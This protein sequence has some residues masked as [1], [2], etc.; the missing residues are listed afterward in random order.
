MGEPAACATCGRRNRVGA[1][2]CAGCGEALPAGCP[3]CGRALAPDANFCDRCGH[4]IPHAAPSDDAVG[5]GAR[6]PGGASVAAAEPAARPAARAA[7]ASSAVRKTVTVLF[8]DLVGSTAFGERV[9][10]ELAREAMARY[11]ELARSAV[12]TN[13]GTVAKFIGDGVMALFGVPRTGEDDA[14]RAVAAGVDLQRDFEAMRRQ[15]ADRFGAEVGLRVGINTGEVVIAD[16]DADVV[17]DALNTAARLEAECPPGAVVVGAETWRLTRSSVGYAPLGEIRVRGRE[18]PVAAFRVVA[19]TIEPPTP[20]REAPTPFVGRTAELDDLRRMF[21]AVVAESRTRVA[22]IV[23][24]PGVGKTRLARELARRIRLE[25]QIMYLECEQSGASTYAP[26]ADLLRSITRIHDGQG[27]DEILAALRALVGDAVDAPRVTELLGAMVGVGPA[28]STE[29]SFY[30]ARRL[31]E[32]HAAQRPLVLIV[33]DLQWA[34]PVLFDLLDHLVRWVSAPMMVVALA[35]PELREV[36]PGLTEPGHHVGLAMALEGLDPDATT[37]LASRLLGSKPLPPELT[38]RLPLSTDGNPLFV[39]ELVRMLADDGVL[40]E[41][42]DGWALAVDV[43]GIDVPPTIQSLLATRI[44]RMP[45]GDRRIAELASVVGVEFPLGALAAIADDFTP[46]ELEASL[47]RLRRREQIQPTGTTWGDQPLYRFHHVLVRDAAYRRLLKKVRADLHP[48]VAAWLEATGDGVFAEDDVTIAHHYEQA[49]RYAR[50]LAVGATGDAGVRAARLFRR[51]ARAA[52]ASDDLVTAGELARRAIDCLDDRDGDAGDE[53]A[54]LLILGCEALLSAGDVH[55]GEALVE[56]LAAVAGD[57]ERLAAWTRCFRAQLV[58]LTDPAGLTDA[59]SSAADAAGQL[60]RLGDHAGVA[61]ARL[62]RAAAVVR[63]GEVAECEVELDRALTAARTAGDQRRITSVLAAAPVAALWGPSPVRRA[64]GRCL[65][66]MRLSR[67]TSDSPSVEAIAVRCQAVLEAMRGN[68]DTARVLLDSARTIAEEVG[69]RHGLLETDLYA[70]IVELLAGRPRQAEPHLRRAHAG[71]G[72]LRIGADAGQAAAYLARALLLQGRLDEAEELAL[73]SDALAGQNPQTAI[74]ARSA[75]AEILSARGD[76]DSALRLAEEAVRLATPTDIVFDHANALMTLARVRRT[77]GD[78]RG[79]HIAAAAAAALYESKGASSGVALAAELAGPVGRARS[80]TDRPVVPAGSEAP[81][82]AH[83][84][85]LVGR[86]LDDGAAVDGAGVDGAGVDGIVAAT[87]TCRDRRAGAEPGRS[88]RE[89]VLGM[90]AGPGGAAPDRPE[91]GT[92]A[93]ADGATGIELELIAAGADEL[94]LCSLGGPTNALVLARWDESTGAIDHLAVY[95]PADLRIAADDLDDLIRRAD[96]SPVLAT[97]LDFLR[98]HRYADAATLEAMTSPGFAVVD[99]RELGFGRIAR[100]DWIEVHRDS[101]IGDGSRGVLVAPRLHRVGEAGWVATSVYRVG[102]EPDRLALS[103]LSVTVGLLDS[104]G[105]VES[106][107]FFPEDALDRALARLDGHAR[108][109]AG[110]RPGGSPA[111]DAVLDA[112]RHVACAIGARDATAFLA[113]WHRDLRFVDHRTIGWDTGD[114]DRMRERFRSLNPD[115][116]TVTDEVRADIVEVHRLEPP[117]MC[118]TGSH[119]VV[120]P[121]GAQLTE[122]H[123]IVSRVDPATGQIEL[124]EEYPDDQLEDAVRRCGELVDEARETV[125]ANDAA[126]V[127]GAAHRRALAGDTEGRAAWLSP[128]LTVAVGDGADVEPA[129]DGGR[130]GIEARAIDH[131]GRADGSG[132]RDGGEARRAAGHGVAHRRLVATRGDR[133]ALVELHDDSTG[134]RPSGFVVD[135]L[136]GDGRLAGVT[137]F[138]SGALTRAIAHLDRRAGE[139]G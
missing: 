125:T 50:E 19:S 14:R 89:A 75:L 93:T 15:L 16:E 56:R 33:D 37:E 102:A 99:H 11:H 135:E 55:A 24:S 64:G 4:P 43:D 112:T 66:V 88:G 34:G 53:L 25:A 21:D 95:D 30:A 77:A 119:T 10:P 39:R 52:L 114:F 91:S 126:Y 73:D 27:P 78:E 117:V 45:P 1:R 12:E 72:Q 139:L 59:A 17:G 40:T 133:L 63:L 116:G 94:A 13:G 31:A 120:T 111:A 98:A 128:D 100:H 90:L 84:R 87:A 38:A 58:V 79:Q 104:Q 9:D 2:F 85:R 48:R 61:T 65:D 127:G 32:I 134:V 60:A 137:R 26:I 46:S 44:E 105:R 67:I 57:D 124:L 70:G 101:A 132:E 35:R 36:R 110:D 7:I 29:E 69:L 121:A 80:I 28:R 49:H 82:V 42:D 20:E 74:A 81:V 83:L 76:H 92:S 113:C 86:P 96:P 122:R 107:E 123:V 8:A 51:A 47:E 23:G 6:A 109:P 103:V 97:S 68:D 41:T 115:D 3:S 5:T 22:T 54:D 136:D 106:L 130:D 62:V 71:L 118:H 18:A 108:G 131:G 129:A 138:G